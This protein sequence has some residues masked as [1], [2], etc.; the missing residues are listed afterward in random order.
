MKYI[1]DLPEAYTSKSALFGDIL[2]IPICLESG[3]RYGIPTGIKLE[4]YTE[5][6]RKA[7][8]DAQEEAWKMASKCLWDIT[9]S[10]SRVI[11]GM[12]C[13]YVPRDMSYQEAKA[14]YESWKAKR[15][16]LSQIRVGDEIDI[17]GEITV[18]TMINKYGEIL[19]VDCDG[20]TYYYNVES[21]L[22]R[23]K[24]TG[25]HFDEVEELLKKI[26]EK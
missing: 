22:K 4:P 15:D 1:V 2:S 10:Q 3:K 14:K 21:Q 18:V 17:D 26:K 25:R 19:S 6:D 23:A 12:D 9:N 20:M 13:V 7:I 8:E 5:P 11:F 16:E 24:K